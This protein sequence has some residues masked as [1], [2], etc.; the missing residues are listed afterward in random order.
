MLRRGWVLSL[1]LL[2]CLF[3]NASS[4]QA[5]TPLETLVQKVEKRRGNWIGLKADLQIKFLSSESRQ[6][7]CAGS[8]L[9]QRLDERI[10]L[11]CF[12]AKN[13]LVFA[14]KTTDREFDLYL[15]SQETVYKG[16]IFSLEDSPAIESH[17]RPLD[18]YRA[19]KPMAI[20]LEHTQT[21][22]REDSSVS[23]KVTRPA[24]EK[25][26]PVRDITVSAKG[27]IVSEAYYALSGKISVKIKRSEFEKTGESIQG[28]ESAFPKKIWLRSYQEAGSSHQTVFRF[29]KITFLPEIAEKD[30]TFPLPEETKELELQDDLSQKS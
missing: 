25:E 29:G 28:V 8:L 9:Y 1:A 7:S 24:G 18:L 17:L 30:F 12:N 21:A 26:L 3:L 15:P 6:A 13:K 27:D 5:Q 20:P 22:P 14:F 4:A 19:F 10:L 23:L 16:N 2:A 11:Q